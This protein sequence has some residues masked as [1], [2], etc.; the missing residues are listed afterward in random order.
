I[1]AL[2]LGDGSQPWPS[3]A[4]G[5]MPSGQGV[6]SNNVYYL[7]LRK[8]EICA[9][10]LTRWVIQ[11]H[12]RASNL[13]ATAKAPPDDDAKQPAKAGLGEPPGNLVFYEGMVLSQTPT[14]IVAYP[15]LVAKLQEAE[16]AYG[17]DPSLK[18]LLARGELRLADGQTQ[19][20][21]NDLLKVLDDNP[22]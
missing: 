10:D 2:R 8:G 1:R 5:D 17:K 6:A 22:T 9:V 18:N 12:N 11:A 3:L 13:P 7:P 16:V 20:A 15:Q 4:T 21:A 14:A 19:K